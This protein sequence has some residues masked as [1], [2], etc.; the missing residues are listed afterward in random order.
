[1][2]ETLRVHPTTSAAKIPT[3]TSVHHNR[4]HYR[5][6]NCTKQEAPPEDKRPTTS[7]VPRFSS[8]FLR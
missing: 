4:K 2:W 7:Q 1:M 8:C 3:K 6:E 5:T